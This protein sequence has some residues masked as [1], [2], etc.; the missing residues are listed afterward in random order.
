MFKKCKISLSIFFIISFILA[1]SLYANDSIFLE[2]KLD[3]DSS[4]ISQNTQLQNQ[5]DPMILD[6]DKNIA[7]IIDNQ[8][9]SKPIEE[10][11]LSDVIRNEKVSPEV[12][13]RIT[14]LINQSQHQLD[15]YRSAMNNY[16]KQVEGKLIDYKKE[17]NNIHN[18]K[19]DM[20]VNLNLAKWMIISLSVGIICLTTIVVIMWKSVVNVN[21]NDVETLFSTEKLKKEIR[22]LDKR[23]EILEIAYKRD[24]RR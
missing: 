4:I 19:D 3:F 8:K 6:A 22:Q 17:L 13:E 20:E 10:T 15:E 21:R 2:E 12:K 14:R 18:F 23:I 16:Y 24:E 5:N 11:T 9:P 7:K 1:L